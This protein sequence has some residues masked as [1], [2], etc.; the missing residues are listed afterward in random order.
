MIVDEDRAGDDD[1]GQRPGPDGAAAAMRV[2][3]RLWLPRNSLFAIVTLTRLRVGYV[4]RVEVRALL[5]ECDAPPSVPEICPNGG[6]ISVAVLSR[7]CELNTSATGQDT[8]RP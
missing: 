7:N 6:C 5:D 1:I 8:A 2:I 3:G 4:E